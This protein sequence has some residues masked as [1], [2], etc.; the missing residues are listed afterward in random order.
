M[1]G[2]ITAGLKLIGRIL[3]KAVTA[4]VAGS[5][6]A[7][8]A[9]HWED[10]LDAGGKAICRA[11]DELDNKKEELSAKCKN[12]KLTWKETIILIGLC[13]KWSATIVYVFIMGALAF[14][15]GMIDGVIEGISKPLIT[16]EVQHG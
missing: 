2:F 1:F 10:F 9:S 6:V 12:R 11:D 3:V 4:V 14:I 5:V 16:K 15:A 8:T 7:C 13:I